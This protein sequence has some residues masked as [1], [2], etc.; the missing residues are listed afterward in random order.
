MKFAVLFGGQS[1]EHEISIVSAIALKDVLNS[2][3]CFIFCDSNREF[4]LI[5]P[6]NMKAIY[7]SKGDYKKS[8][9]I[10]LSNGGFFANTLFSKKKIE[11]DV[12]INLIHGC[13]GEDGKIAA[14]FDFYNIAY[15][16]PRMQASVMG[17]NKALTKLLAKEAGVNSLDYEVITKKDNPK[18][19][20]PYIIKPCSLGSSIGVKVVKSKNELDYAKDEAFEFDDSAIVEPFIE[21]V[22]EY[23]LAGCKIGDEILYSVIEEPVKNGILDFEQKYMHFGD[24]EKSAKAGISA[25][26]EKKMKDSF[27]KLYETGG[28]DGALIRCDF[29]VINNEVYLNEINANPGS[30][31]NYLF[32]NFSEVVEKLASNLPN[33]RKI[34]VNYKYVSSIS[35]KK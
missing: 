6:E 35:A 18:M 1:F 4:Y 22:K 3:L 12:V 5:E 29:F 25:E 10:F 32:D 33:A 8:K 16:G 7:F 2:S 21:N 19:N 30:M 9:Q 15:I 24:K 23:N 14:L 27:K 31:A 34:P 28:F 13:D 17:Y 20:F 26:I 11:F